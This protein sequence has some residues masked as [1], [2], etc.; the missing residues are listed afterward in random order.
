MVA[1]P[2]ESDNAYVRGKDILNLQGKPNDKQN[3]S[4]LPRYDTMDAIEI[5][6]GRFSESYGTSIPQNQ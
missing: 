6:Q 3:D 1:G 2:D 4:S 5:P